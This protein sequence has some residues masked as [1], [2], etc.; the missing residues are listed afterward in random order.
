M[1]FYFVLG[2]ALPFILSATGPGG[3]APMQSL[4]VY[5]AYC[6]YIA[7]STAAEGAILSSL[8]KVL[9]PETGV[10]PL[11]CNRYLHAKWWQGQIASLATFV[12]VGFL[13]SAVSCLRAGSHGHG[14]VAELKE[15]EESIAAAATKLYR[16][17]EKAVVS[18][19][20]SEDAAALLAPL[21]IVLAVITAPILIMSHYRRVRLLWEFRKPAPTVHRLLPN[22]YRNS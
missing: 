12:H 11:A 8:R 9:K 10:G 4:V 5:G 7:L 17:E 16:D 3:C 2:I 1:F 22:A 6:G 13:A 15:L 21:S 18:A 19:A 14:L 20:T